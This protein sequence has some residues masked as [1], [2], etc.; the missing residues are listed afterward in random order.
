MG[1][2]ALID[3]VREICARDPRFHAD[4]YLFV[5]E[6]LEFT[7]KM[8]NKPNKSGRERHVAGRELLEGVRHFALQ[9]Y[10][11]MAF[12]VL[13]RWGIERTEDI[14]EI[15]FNLVDAGKLRKTDEDSKSDFANGFDFTDAFVVPFLPETGK[16]GPSARATRSSKD[17]QKR[18]TGNSSSETT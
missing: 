15:V 18:Q 9:E 3:A 10:G 1:D 17:P 14:G 8:L 16:D 5:L 2:S 12:T 4:S 13:S 11:P 7:A 6:T